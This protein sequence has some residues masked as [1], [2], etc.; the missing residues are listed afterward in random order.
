MTSCW[1]GCFRVTARL[2][3]SL[4]GVLKAY[5]RLCWQSQT[6]HAASPYHRSGKPLSRRRG[7][8]PV[9]GHATNRI[10]PFFPGPFFFFPRTRLAPKVVGQ[11]S[12]RR[13]WNRPPFLA[14][15]LTRIISRWPRHVLDDTLQE[16][17]P[18][19]VAILG[20]SGGFFASSWHAGDFVELMEEANLVDWS[21]WA[22]GVFFLLEPPVGR[23]FARVDFGCFSRGQRVGPL[24]YV[25]VFEPSAGRFPSCLSTVLMPALLD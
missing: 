8:T 4:S 17:R 11:N 13:Q 21:R 19:G 23:A 7:T 6:R 20:H 15:F 14:Q 12:P 10:V 3:S 18:P 9:S 16:T 25:F 5:S 24:F 22:S 1:F 2:L